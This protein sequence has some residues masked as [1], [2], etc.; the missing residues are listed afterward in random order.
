MGTDLQ[1]DKDVI[2]GD[3]ISTSFPY[4]SWGSL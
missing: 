2:D 1:K 4:S 3:Y